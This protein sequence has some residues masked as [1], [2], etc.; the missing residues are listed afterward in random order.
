MKIYMQRFREM[1][2]EFGR[3]QSGAG[4]GKVALVHGPV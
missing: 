2:I 3:L 4:F 1:D